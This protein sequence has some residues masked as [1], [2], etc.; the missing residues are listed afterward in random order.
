MNDFRGQQN[1]SRNEKPDSKNHRNRSFGYQSD[2]LNPENRSSGCRIRFLNSKNK[3]FDRRSRFFG[4][5]A[6]SFN[7]RSA[8]FGPPRLDR[9][10]VC[11]AFAGRR[12]LQ[13]VC[14]RR[15]RKRSLPNGSIDSFAPLVQPLGLAV[16]VARFPA[17][18]F[19]EQKCGPHLTRK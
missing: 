3:A 10:Y 1:Q 5:G 9:H 11:R 15:T 4:Y 6:G 16:D 14:P 8:T 18:P 2:S 17:A 12:L 13:E 7:R 19:I